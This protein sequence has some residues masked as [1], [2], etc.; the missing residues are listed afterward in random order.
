MNTV[1][2]HIYP[3]LARVPGEDTLADSTT[4]IPFAWHPRFTSTDTRRGG[5]G[6][7]AP[8]HSLVRPEDPQ[9]GQSQSHGK[10]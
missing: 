1:H 4:Y 6:D 10:D 9:P 2:I 3:G 7:A 5:L 8:A